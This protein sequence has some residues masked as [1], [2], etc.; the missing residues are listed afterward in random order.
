MNYFIKKHI[1]L[2]MNY[3]GLNLKKGQINIFA[4]ADVSLKYFLD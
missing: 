1:A 4:G 2:E 3:L